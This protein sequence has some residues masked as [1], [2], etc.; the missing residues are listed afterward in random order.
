MRL[1]ASQSRL[2][3]SAI[4]QLHNVDALASLQL[5]LQLFMQLSLGSSLGSSPQLGP[6][7]SD[8]AIWNLYGLHLLIIVPLMEYLEVLI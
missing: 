8:L 2:C 5:F 4:L 1:V 3:S 7:S 6:F